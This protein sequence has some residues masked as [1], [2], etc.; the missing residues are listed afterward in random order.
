VPAAGQ[1]IRLVPAQPHVQTSVLL[2]GLDQPHGLAVDASTLYVA[3]SDEI[4]AFDY[5]GGRADG[6]RVVASGLPD[7]RS[8][9]LGGAYAHALKSVAIG[10]DGAVYFSI[11]STGN[12]TADDRAA[13]P[14]RATIMR[15]PPGGGPPS[16]PPVCAMERGWR[17]H[18][19]GRYGPQSTIAIRS[20]TRTWGRRTEK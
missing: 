20:P 4:D 6:R 9:E 7:A 18:R 1:V 3:E 10:P 19:M 5:S 11:G 12:V 13:D 16:S 14:P 17:S 8:P 15:V 2:D